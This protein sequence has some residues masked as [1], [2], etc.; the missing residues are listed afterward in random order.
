MQDTNSLVAAAPVPAALPAHVL[1]L[2]LA[3]TRQLFDSMDPAPFHERDLDPK[4]VTYIV[5]WAREAPAG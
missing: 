4:A 2:Y 3:D 1:K 5:D